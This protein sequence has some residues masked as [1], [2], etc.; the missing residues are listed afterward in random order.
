MALASCGDNRTQDK[1]KQKTPKA[2]EDKSSSYE[3]ISKRGNDDL[4][5]GLYNEVVRKDIDLKKLEDRIDDE[6]F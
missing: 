6:N 1:P 5:E 3:I 4:L 2:L